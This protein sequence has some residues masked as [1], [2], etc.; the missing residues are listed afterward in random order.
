MPPPLSARSLYFLLVRAN[1]R[2]T[3]AMDGIRGGMSGSPIM[4]DEGAAIGIVAA[5]GGVA[6]S[7]EPHTEGTPNPRLIIDLPGWLLR[8][9]L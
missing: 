7:S 3:E 2:V 4:S 9:V 1:L 5:S 8:E 6:G